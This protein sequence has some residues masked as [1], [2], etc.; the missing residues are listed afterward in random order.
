MINQFPALF[1]PLNIG[2]LTLKNRLVFP[3]VGG[4]PKNELAEFLAVRA[5]GGTG[6][7]FI[8]GGLLEHDI[9]G[10]LIHI[11]SD[12]TIPLLREIAKEV[13][14]YG[15]KIGCQVE[16]QGQQTD[17][18]EVT[19][20][21]PSPIPWSPN[22]RVPRE[23]TIEEIR[24]L[25][26]EF[27][28]AIRRIRDAGYD[29]A[30]I[31]G[32]HGY[33]ITQFL[34]PRT[35]KRTDEYGGSATNR[36]RFLV[37][38]IRR[39]RE[40]VGDAFPISCR[41][42]ASDH[43]EGGLTPQDTMFFAR[44]AEQ[45][46]LSLISLSA[47]VYGAPYM[48]PP[49]YLP[50][51]LNVEVAR[52]VKQVV[53]IPVCVAGRIDDAQLAEQILEDRKADFIALG[54]PLYVDPELPNKLMRGEVERVRPCIYCNNGCTARM[55]F[56]S[57]ISRCTVNPWVGQEEA[58]V[59][60]KAERVKKILIAG[61]GLAG[62]EAARV[63]ASRGHKVTIYEKENSLGG[64]W[65]MAAIPP[66]KDSF[67][68]YLKW[69]INEVKLAGVEVKLRTPLSLNDLKIDNPDAVILATG[70]L[71]AIPPV[72]GIETAVLAWDVLKG[73]A[74]VGDN[75]LIV[76]GNA[77]GLEIAHL[78]AV[79]GK[80]ITVIE[81]SSRFGADMPPMV[82][83][84][85]RKSLNDHGVRLLPSMKLKQI[86]ANKDVVAETNEGEK[87]LSGYS[88]VILATG[89]RSYDE[90]KSLLEPVSRELYV[91][92]DAKQPRSG[93][94]AVAEGAQVGLLI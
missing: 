10:D 77:T 48:I 4:I 85:L 12:E 31:H 28:D 70:A 34:S 73:K 18:A 38:I 3:P 25:V 7:I 29:I 19:P 42:N 62:M 24:N 30:E 44:Q 27:S 41:L 56:R 78:L 61:G 82:R 64:Q 39:A 69:L 11:Y 91:I 40:K 60:P 46:G 55:E 53:K 93:L 67:L 79:Q 6:L 83:W 66:S 5:K 35:N 49:S 1:S 57:L 9:P 90:L 43:V 21:A 22:A 65:L 89:V 92:G 36:A 32:A 14:S 26:E 81:M 20:V 23:L 71:P 52:Q 13:H 8:G 75:V 15:A 51:G 45:A 58:Q 54:R 33:L 17:F 74:K 80:S 86:S 2:Q 16:H 94:E 88:D 87:I 72:K 47:G 37:E 68:R 84:H 50:R 76:G 59:I 63:A